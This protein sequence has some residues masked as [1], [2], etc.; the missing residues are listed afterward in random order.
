M[1]KARYLVEATCLTVAVTLGALMDRLCIVGGLVPSLLI[2]AGVEALVSGD[3]RHLLPVGEYRGVRV[4]A[5]QALLA[6]LRRA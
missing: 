5:P 6:E 4:V 2:E 1:D 3:R